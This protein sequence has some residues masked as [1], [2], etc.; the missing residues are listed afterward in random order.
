ME[1]IMGLVLFIIVGA[2]IVFFIYNP[3]KTKKLDNNNSNVAIGKQKL[4]EL[5]NDL[6]QNFID[7]ENYQHAKNEIEQN[8]ATELEDF[9]QIEDKKPSIIFAALAIVFIIVS[10]FLIYQKVKSEVVVL[11][12]NT[13]EILQ[14]N[15]ERD[16][17]DSKSWQM[18]GFSLSLKNQIPAAVDAYKK[19]YELGNRDINLLTEYASI[20]ATIN[21]GKFDGT[22][23]KLVREALEIDTNSIKALY[24][25]GI[26]AANSGIFDLSKGLW[27][28]ALKLSEPRSEDEKMLLNVLEQLDNFTNESPQ[29][30]VE[31]HITI[32]IP[33][34]L[35][36]KRFDDFIMVYA[37]NATGR[38][39]PIAIEK[40]KL[41]D[42]NGIVILNDGNSV[43]PTNKLSDAQDIVIVARLSKSG[44]AFKQ[45][46]DIDI[47][48]KIMRAKTQS[49]ELNF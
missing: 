14:N 23:A 33:E 16:P 32:D 34:A 28:K 18:L 27:E 30:T 9:A 39:M 47:I 19:S 41:T 20:L 13:I 44:S 35:Y 11:P 6:E 15:I 8:L 1:E 7:K 3:P 2:T 37:K 49:V 29:S 46:D 36:K 17:S 12:Q 21:G 24:L 48:S 22:P 31:I 5:K 45:P 4:Q 10:S 43:M 38:P 42:F 40:I 25:A 26:I